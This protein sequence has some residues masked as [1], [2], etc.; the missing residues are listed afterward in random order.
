MVF[1][2]TMFILV[3]HVVSCLW[4]FWARVDNNPN[5]WIKSY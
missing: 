4:I 5:N 1:F 2:I 3:I